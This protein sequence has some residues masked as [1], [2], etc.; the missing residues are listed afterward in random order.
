MDLD[1]GKILSTTDIFRV[2]ESPP[3]M[4]LLWVASII[5]VLLLC[6]M[7]DVNPLSK[8]PLVTEKS[9]WDIGGKKAKESFAINARGVVERGFKQVCTPPRK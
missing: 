1:L 9:F 5:T 2:A 8:V 3:Y 7:R 4:S 6:Y